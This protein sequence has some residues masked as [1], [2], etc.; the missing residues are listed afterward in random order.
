MM[1][2]LSIRSTWSTAATLPL[3]LSKTK[4]LGYTRKDDLQKGDLL[5]IQ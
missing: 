3:L 5:Y 2:C 1:L 4:Q